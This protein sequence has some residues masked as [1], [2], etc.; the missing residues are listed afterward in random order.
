MALAVLLKG[1]SQPGKRALQG[2][3]QLGFMT[4][5]IGEIPDYDFCLSVRVFR[6]RDFPVD[7]G[8]QGHE[9]ILP[10]IVRVYLDLKRVG[11][12]TSIV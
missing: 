7:V 10:G 4:G 11:W 2:V 5:K 12:I 9:I 8:V 3:V 6:F 1:F